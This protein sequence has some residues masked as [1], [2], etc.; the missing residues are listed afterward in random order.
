MGDAGWGRSGECRQANEDL[1]LT[2]TRH[3]IDLKPSSDGNNAEQTKERC[4][5]LCNKYSWC[6]AA[7]VVL[8]T[9]PECNL[10]TDRPAFE[11]VFG[12]RQEYRWG[13]ITTIDDVDYIT[14][15]GG[16]GCR[17]NDPDAN[18]FDGG[19]V[20]PRRDYFCYKKKG[21]RQIENIKI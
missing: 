6:Y 12:P 9:W 19:S 8:G 5:K 3:Y 10:I 21:T 4:L 7:E 15:C 18:N 11:G 1:P 2:F 14:Y 17:E 16:M 13:D 20:R